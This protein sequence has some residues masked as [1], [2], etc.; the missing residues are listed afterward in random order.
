[1]LLSRSSL[2]DWWDRSQKMNQFRSS[3]VG[4]RR[5]AHSL[6]SSRAALKLCLGLDPPSEERG[7]SGPARRRR[8]AVAAVFICN[9]LEP[10]C[11]GV[12]LNHGFQICVVPLWSWAVGSST[13]EAQRSFDMVAGRHDGSG[14]RSG[15]NGIAVRS[16]IVKSAAPSSASTTNSAVPMPPLPEMKFVPVN[17]PERIRALGPLRATVGQ[18]DRVKAETGVDSQIPNAAS[19]EAL[20]DV[21]A[22]RLSRYA[23]ED[24]LFSMLGIRVGKS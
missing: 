3:E 7:W 8:R 9:V 16:T 21:K 13:R 11:S 19:R 23:E 20:A 1:M 24:E 6:S 22:G 4:H 18:T 14:S 2:T 15:S 12:M 5:A 17:P 10:G